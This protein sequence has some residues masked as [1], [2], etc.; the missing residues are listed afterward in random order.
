[1]TSRNQATLESVLAE[2]S[3]LYPDMRFG[4]LIEMV[5][6]LAGE[7]T[8]ENAFD[9]DDAKLLQTAIAHLSKRLQQ[10]SVPKGSVS[11]TR[12]E[13]LQL[14]RELQDRYPDWRYGQLAANVA[15]WSDVSLYDAEDEQLLA[16]GRQHLVAG[17]V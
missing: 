6:V 4:Q 9:V 12:R 15:G 16:A 5:A 17:Q 8:P 1:M 7:E 10:R 2:L 13:V 11:A 3:E 14:F